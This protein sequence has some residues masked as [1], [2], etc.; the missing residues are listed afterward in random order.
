MAWSRWRGVAVALA[1]ALAPLPGRGADAPDAAQWL[2]WERDRGML[3]NFGAVGQP[4]DGD[5]RAAYGIVDDAAR[6][7]IFRRV[8]YDI[9][10][11]QERI[12]RAGLPEP[13]WCCGF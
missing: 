2:A 13:R 12:L 3:V 9:Q 1:V 5:P 8:D 6:R 7:I 11:A 4:R 10:T